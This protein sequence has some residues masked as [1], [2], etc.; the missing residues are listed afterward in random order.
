MWKFDI[1]EDWEK[2]WSEKHL[3]KWNDLL[4]QSS[5]S[6]VFFHPLLVRIWIDTYLP[7]RNFTPIF[8]WGESENGNN[9]A[10]LPLVLWRKDWRGA[11]LYSIIPVGYSDYDYHDP[12]FINSPDAV[13]LATYWEELLIRLQSYHADEVL[14]NGFRDRCIASNGLWLQGEI[15]PSLDLTKI[16]SEES[17]MAFFGT[18][19]RGD[20]RRQMRRL[21][22]MGTLRFVEYASEKD[23]PE[24][25]FEQFMDAHRQRWPNA[26]KAPLFHERLVE[27]CSLNAPIHFSAMM[28]DE[29]PIA[30]HLGFEF[31]GVYYYYMPAGNP[32]FQKQSPVKIHLYY[33]ILRAIGKKYVLYDH[34]RGDETYKSGWS[35]GLQ[36]VNNRI[37]HSGR[38]SSMIKH[39][40]IKVKEFIRK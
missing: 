9:S 31:Q 23:I 3:C 8:V 7:L 39:G 20:I 27:A 10:F 29:T 19:L 4:M 16:N 34:L 36:Y 11:F 38:I 37:I 1:I 18:K 25:L 2:V 21:G 40:L 26:Y 32:D 12:L 33:L 28:L 6:H 13:E 35:D 17:L 22:E 30:W 5:T 15:C 14:L 24:G